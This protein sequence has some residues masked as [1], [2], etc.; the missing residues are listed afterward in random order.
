MSVKVFVDTNVLVYS[1]DASEPEKQRQAMVWMK[2]LWASRTGQL[3]FQVGGA[4][5]YGITE[6]TTL[7]SE[8]NGVG[9]QKRESA[10]H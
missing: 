6:Y 2:H 3:S 5:T 1:R 8:P 9:L 4:K 10:T 7:K